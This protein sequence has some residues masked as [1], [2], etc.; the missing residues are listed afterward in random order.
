MFFG[1]LKVVRRV[2]SGVV[3]E[4]FGFFEFA[5]KTVFFAGTTPTKFCFL[6]EIYDAMLKQLL[7]HDLVDEIPQK[8]H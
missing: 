6:G 7:F 4:N 8:K 3:S 5:T 2:K 1:F